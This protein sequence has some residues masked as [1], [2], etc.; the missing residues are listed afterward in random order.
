MLY[1]LFILRVIH[2]TQTNILASFCQ[3]TPYCFFSLQLRE[4]E[5]RRNN[6]WKFNSLLIADSHDVTKLKNHITN[7]LLFIAR[8]KVSDDQSRWEQLKYE[9]SKFS[10]KFSK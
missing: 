1:V 5:T 2:V 4:K 6:F 8:E 3:I 7:T 9:I 10:M